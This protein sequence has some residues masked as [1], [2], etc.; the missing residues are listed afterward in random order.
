MSTTAYKR[1]QL[2][3]SNFN[4]DP[5]TFSIMDV[6]EVWCFSHGMVSH[7]NASEYP[8]YTVSADTVLRTILIERAYKAK[9]RKL[10]G[11]LFSNK[12][13]RLRRRDIDNEI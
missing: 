4:R 1:L 3:I 2:N 11:S 6:W 8:L 7:R 13:K 9:Q 5:N 12:L 10:S